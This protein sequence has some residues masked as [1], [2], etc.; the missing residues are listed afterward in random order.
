MRRRATAA[1]VALLCVGVAVMAAMSLAIGSGDVPVPRVLAIV[2]GQASGTVEASIVL[3]Q[4][5]PRTCVAIIAGSALGVAGALSQSLT[6]NP[7]AEPGTLG[8]SSGASLALVVSLLLLPGLSIG[9]QLGFA[10]V[11]A[12]ASG[13]VVLAIG[14]VMS[15]RTSTVRLVLAGA[16]W[17]ALASAL[18]L[19]LIHI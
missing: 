4:R 19:S 2:T 3:Q 6:R 16:A 9:A 13:A 12:A 17:S 1:S 7:L 15:G 14:G 8:V 5:L 10:M 11:G 18:T